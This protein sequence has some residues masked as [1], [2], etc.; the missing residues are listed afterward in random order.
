MTTEIE[1]AVITSNELYYDIITV[2]DGNRTPIIASS[3]GNINTRQYESLL[4]PYM[5]YSWGSETTTINLLENGI[6]LQEGLI[7]EARPREWVYKPMEAGEITLSI[8]AGNVIK[9]F[10]LNVSPAL[11]AVKAV[12]A[13]QLL[14]LTPISKSNAS[15]DKNK[16][17]NSIPIDAINPSPMITSTLTDFDYTTNG[18]LPDVNGDATLRVSS[19]ARVDIPFKP[20]ATN[21]KKYRLYYGV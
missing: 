8:Q 13:N 1:G 4:I 7:V 14:Y 9:N 18:W 16:W 11:I 15:E 17:N 10:T 3:M 20:F 21:M 19:D 6:I 5:V 12:T 2:V